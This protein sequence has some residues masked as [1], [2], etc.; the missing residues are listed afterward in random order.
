MSTATQKTLEGLNAIFGCTSDDISV[1]SPGL[2]ERFMSALDNIFGCTADDIFNEAECGSQQT[3][4]Q[5][6]PNNKFDLNNFL[7]QAPSADSPQFKEYIDNLRRPPRSHPKQYQLLFTKECKKF[8]RKLNKRFKQPSPKWETIPRDE[9]L[10]PTLQFG[11][12][13]KKKNLSF[14]KRIRQIRLFPMD[15]DTVE[16]H[17]ETLPSNEESKTSQ[18]DSPINTVPTETQTVDYETETDGNRSW[19]TDYIDIKSCDEHL[20]S[21]IMD[22]KRPDRVQQSA[23]NIIA[24]RKRLLDLRLEASRLRR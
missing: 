23:C 12:T 24:R 19:H 5:W 15:D 13:A 2:D 1:E 17:H 9:N 7:K 21:D 4:T 18:E 8:S 14:R 22:P 20:I 11:Q 10:R 16:S 6:N 3:T